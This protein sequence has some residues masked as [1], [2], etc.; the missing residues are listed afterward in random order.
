[1]Y[2]SYNHFYHNTLYKRHSHFHFFLLQNHFKLSSCNLYTINTSKNNIIIIR[3]KTADVGD[4]LQA[5]NIT[6]GQI[7]VVKYYGYPILQL[8]NTDDFRYERKPSCAYHKIDTFHCQQAHKG[9][10]W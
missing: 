7:F 2:Q 5:W 8:I 4:L 9:G 6:G 1:V 10:H 3:T